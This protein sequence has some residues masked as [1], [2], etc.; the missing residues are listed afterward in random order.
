MGDF[1]DFAV[2]IEDARHLSP[3]TLV[4]LHPKKLHKY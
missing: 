1:N 3:E 4:L 2:N